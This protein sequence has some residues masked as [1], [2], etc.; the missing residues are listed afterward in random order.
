MR[1]KIK[2]QL[3]NYPLT[4]YF[5]LLLVLTAA[6]MSWFHLSFAWQFN[7]NQFL[8]WINRHAVTLS[9]GVIGLL[10]LTLIG[11]AVA[12]RQTSKLTTDEYYLWL[13]QRGTRTLFP[14][15]T[16]LHDWLR[17]RV[18]VYRWWNNQPFVSSIHWLAL[19]VTIGL[20]L[21]VG[22]RA[23]LAGPCFALAINSDTS[24]SGAV[25]YSDVTINSGATLTIAGGTTA[26]LDSLT[27]GTND[28]STNGFVVF[29]GDTLND[30]GV[31]MTVTNGVVV[32]SGSSM[33]GNGQGYL[34]GTAGSPTGAGPG[35]G[36][37]NAATWAGGG[38]H[39]GVG[40]TVNG[41]NGGTTYDSASAPVNLGSGG[42]RGS[43]G[44]GGAGGAALKITAGGTIQI[45]GTVAANGASTG[46]GGAGGS[47]WLAAGT[48]SGAGTISANGGN[49]AV[50]GG[51]G[52]G[53]RVYQQC[54]SGSSPTPT[55]SAGSP[56]AQGGLPT[57][58][59][60]NGSVGQQG[61]ATALTVTG[62]VSAAAGTAQSP[63]VTAVDGVGATVTTYTGTITFSST[64]AQAV[65][66]GTYTFLVGD[67]GVHL[68][69][70]G[71]T[72]KTAGSQT[73]T[74][75]DQSALHGAQTVT[76]TPGIAA[77]LT[78]SG[79]P[80]S[81]AAGTASTVTLGAK[82]AYNNAATAYS[83][84]VHFAT[85]DARAVLPANYTFVGADNGSKTF[86]GGVTLKTAGS[87]TVAVTDQANSLAATQTATVTPGSAAALAL[88]GLPASAVAGAS[89][90]AT[91]T[92]QDN[93]GN[94]VTSYA[95]QIHF[96]ATDSQASLPGDYTFLVA[97]GGVKTFSGIVLKTAGSQTVT[98]A[99]SLGA[100][101]STSQITAISAGV[102]NRLTLGF[103]ATLSAATIVAGTPLSPVVAISDAY[104]NTVAGYT[105]TLS[106]T[107]TDPQAT[108]PANTGL[109]AADNGSKTFTGGV[110]LRTAGAQTLSVLGSVAPGSL[111]TIFGPSQ[112]R[113]ISKA[114]AADASPIT[115]ASATLVISPAAASSLL[116]QSSARSTIAGAGFGLT[117][118]AQDAY[119][120]TANRYAG[121]V[122]FSSTDATASLPL[123]TTFV[124]ADGGNKKFNGVVLR[125]AGDQ[126]ITVRDATS[127]TLQGQT[128]V[129]VRPA[130]LA[131]YALSG[132]V[133]QVVNVGWVEAVSGVDAF[134]NVVTTN[135]SA[136][137]TPTSSGQARFYTGTSDAAAL[138]TTT[139]TAGL[140]SLYVKD[141]AAETLVLTVTD[142]NGL[143]GHS[144][145]ITVLAAAGGGTTPP[146]STGGGTVINQTSQLVR[147]FFA[148]QPSL[149]HRAAVFLSL[150]G[151]I[152][153]F[154]SFAPIGVMLASAVTASAAQG[155]SA[156]Y[157]F[158][159]SLL[160][161]QARRRSR[162]GVVRQALTGVPIAGVFVELLDEQGQRISRNLTD[163]TGRYGF[164]VSQPGQYQLKIANPLYGTYLSPILKVAD[165]QQG[166]VVAD[167][168]LLPIN[169]RLAPRLVRALGWLKLAKILGWLYWPTLIGGSALVALLL[170][171]QVTIGRLLLAVIYLVFWVAK[172]VELGFDR[173]FGTVVDA[174][175]NQTL[176]L[177]V[178]QLTLSGGDGQTLVRST[179]TDEHG[180]FLFTVRPD[181]YDVIVT[182][183]GY[184][185]IDVRLTGDK[186]NKQIKLE[187][188]VA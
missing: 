27:V 173:P 179:I 81:V 185:P 188:Q 146:G 48:C 69:P 187:K 91:L 107:S 42:G 53:G 104:G 17:L 71:V 137:L 60:G 136:V 55:A 63:T 28:G 127:V 102:A 51:A 33:L 82:D 66:P 159:G 174:K 168:S 64:D 32:Y 12:Y 72:L 23:T 175:T 120:N 134:G 76:I 139:L 124:A 183:E 150:V 50:N 100:L 39:G 58:P 13:H 142:Q 151:P 4:L 97:D 101:K 180:R 99:D 116:L 154:F 118:T 112:N 59:A 171:E 155:G 186:L 93:Y 169:S 40:G 2:R 31:T 115:G 125:Q 92:V 87:Q 41:G 130:E 148:N 114:L 11:S 7:F 133:G 19:T 62:L 178:V 163:Q 84:T 75:T 89:A 164:L 1:E 85:A 45:S 117:V 165:P 161:L 167:I 34:G 67:H 131:S 138:A 103:A 6:L 108:L 88:T 94:S 3:A 25:C 123:T 65:F 170:L 113:F 172:L 79:L 86:S 177:A 80:G 10:G 132:P 109:T 49:G 119:G 147:A 111:S 166:L 156:L 77:T 128:S 74:V 52:G 21:F 46:S 37:S 44:N 182:K 126:K 149:L 176:S 36:G 122:S 30:V 129:P 68:F 143:V 20:S 152:A 141:S 184:A 181:E 43:S 121:T 70:S 24:W 162:W 29:Q 106:F 78:L 90:S 145:P 54:T 61:V 110:I 144:S 22:A 160:P 35:G 38:G 98:V 135:S 57:T 105:G 14:F 158:F 15:F 153:A 73:V 83:G 157:L 96:S 9:I 26:T 18:A 47:V 140:A 5:G 56:V 8:F 16:P 95:G